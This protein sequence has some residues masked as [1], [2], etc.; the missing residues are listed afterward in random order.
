[1]FTVSSVTLYAMHKL[2]KVSDDENVCTKYI[3]KKMFTVSSVTLL[4][5]TRFRAKKRLRE[6]LTVLRPSPGLPR[7][8]AG[9][10]RPAHDGAE[11]RAQNAERRAQH[12]VIIPVT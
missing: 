4:Q 2:Q 10:R 6:Q 5:C 3:Q 7:E 8:C 9:A 11:H 1:M 12:R